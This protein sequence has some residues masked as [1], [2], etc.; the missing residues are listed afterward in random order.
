MPV[1]VVLHMPVGYT[2]LYAKRLQEVSELNVQEARE[3]RPTGRGQMVLAPAG[4]HLILR[5][6]D[7]STVVA[8][9]DA[10][11]FD[12]PHRPAVDVLFRSAADVYEERVLGIVMTGMGNDGLQGAAWIKAK[13]GLVYVEAQETV[14][15]T[16]CRGRSPRRALPTALCPSRSMAQ[17]ILETV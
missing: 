8:H 3:G 9:L 11:P 1:A 12:T 4:R 7:S 14:S 5:R 16:A 13:N 15:S 10:R 17:A 2:A 6:Q